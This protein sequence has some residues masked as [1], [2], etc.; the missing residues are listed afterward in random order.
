MLA[1]RD[2]QSGMR[3]ADAGSS[4]T[5]FARDLLSTKDAWGIAGNLVYVGSQWGMLAT[6]A[7][8]ATPNMLGQFALGFAITAPIISFSQ[9]QLRTIL[10]SV[11][12]ALAVTLAGATPD[13]PAAS[14]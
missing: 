10:M 7:R 2:F 8:I 14:L 1:E 3:V 4:E 13:R 12:M 6:L 5:F 11:G 9:L